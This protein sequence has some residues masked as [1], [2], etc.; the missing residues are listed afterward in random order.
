MSREIAAHYEQIEEANRLHGGRGFLEFA[1]TCEIIERHFAPPP[2]VVFDIGGA[3]GVY[4]FWLAEHDYEVHLTDLL[5]KHIE[6]ARAEAA[7][8]TGRAPASMT[9][10]DARKLDRADGS[11]DAALLL[12]PLYHL[13][14]RA[15]RVAALGEARRVLRPGGVLIAAAISRFASTLDGLARDLHADPA[16]VTMRNRDLLDGQHRNATGRPEY[17]TTAFF[18]HPDELAAEFA[19]A[20]LRHEATLAVEGPAWLLGDFDAQWADFARRER[21]L[22]AIRRI[23]SEPSLLGASAHLLA[24]G[25]H[26]A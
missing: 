17:F 5:E 19:D 16:F 9:V 21:M 13:N 4:A 24:I 2:A 22:D 10:G 11:V 26:R 7:R 14:E 18:H 20:G 1:R 8:R 25:Q 23:E 15:D 3:A 6:Q 12:G